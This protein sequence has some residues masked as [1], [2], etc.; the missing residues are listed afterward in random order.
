MKNSDK[1]LSCLF[2]WYKEGD[3]NLLITMF[4]FS[5]LFT[6]PEFNFLCSD[7]NFFCILRRVAL[8]VI[9]PGFLHF[10]PIPCK[11]FCKLI[12]YISVM[13]LSSHA[14]HVL[15]F[16]PLLHFSIFCQIPTTRC[17]AWWQKL[18][19]PFMLQV[20]RKHVHGFFLRLSS[21]PTAGSCYFPPLLFF[22]CSVCPFLTCKVN[23]WSEKPL[24]V[25]RCTLTWF[26]PPPS[27]AELFIF[28]WP[29]SEITAV[30]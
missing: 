6:W 27:T 1:F 15:P 25:I 7:P 22:A 23:F 14:S 13:S 28:L 5:W 30:L 20:F 19:E 26:E 18:I 8:S 9:T 3:I 12:L 17:I 24:V 2:S 10:P 29:C 16:H 11:G 4:N 21:S